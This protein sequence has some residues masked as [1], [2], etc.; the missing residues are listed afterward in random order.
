[1]HLEALLPEPLLCSCLAQPNDECTG[2]SGGRYLELQQH[3]TQQ[4]IEI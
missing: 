3:I 4:Q 1:M 2:T